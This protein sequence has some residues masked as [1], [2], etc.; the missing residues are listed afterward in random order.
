M[1]RIIPIILLLTIVQCGIA[2]NPFENYRLPVDYEVL[3]AGGFAEPRA[4]HFHGGID[5]KTYGEGKPLYALSDGYVSRISVSPWGYGLAIY[6]NYDNGYTSVYGHISKYAGEIAEFVK[7]TQYEKQSFSI[8]VNLSPLDLPIKKGQ[9]VAYSGNTGGSAGPHL[10]FEIRETQ[11]NTSINTEGNIIKVPDHI[12]PS[13]S[14]VVVY[15]MDNKSSVCGKGNKKRYILANISTGNYK[16]SN[17]VYASGKIGIGVEYTDKMDLVSNR[18]G[19]KKVDLI[20]NDK[21]IYTCTFDKIDMEKQA[22]KNSCYDFNYH[23]SEGRYIQKLFVEPNNTLDI[24]TNLINNGYTEIS[25]NDSAK[26][27]I[28]ITDFFNNT[29]KINF[30]IKSDTSSNI[31][32]N[33]EPKLRWNQ[34]NILE[35]DDCKVEI[36]SACLFDDRAITLTNVGTKKYSAIYKLGDENE[37]VNKPFRVS[38]KNTNVPEEHISQAFV[39][40]ELKGKLGYLT[41]KN[42]NGYLTAETKRFGKF[43]ILLDTI[44]PTI[45]VNSLTYNMTGRRYMDFKISDNLSGIKS[46]NIFINDKWVL[47]EFEPKNSTLRYY[48]DK[49]LPKAESYHLKVVVVDEVGNEKVYEYNFI[50]N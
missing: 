47:G 7:N 34:N 35:V 4:T 40:R 13:A 25:K 23:A 48:F 16:L 43:Y 12:P 50:R 45:R 22:Q 21:K 49:R 39:C 20:V 30:T 17:P 3:L 8:D 5:I 14:S 46:F 24:Y 1:K 18:F 10:H 6:I 15:P 38:I 28:L 29:S 33:T 27:Q 44:A 9:I 19:A 31:W 2:Q 36:D 26:V 11:T 41:T 32:Y 37:A 42:A